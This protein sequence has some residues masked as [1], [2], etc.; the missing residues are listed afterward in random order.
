VRRTLNRTDFLAACKASDTRNKAL[1][2]IR[3][4]GA[5]IILAVFRMLK[6]SLVH[7][8][9]NR[10]VL[11]AVKETHGII[12]DFAAVVGGYV[13]LTSVEETI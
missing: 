6:N 11:Q 9:E 13:S 4:R 5:D 2:E 3:D 12:T 10:A 1:E 7:A 8:T